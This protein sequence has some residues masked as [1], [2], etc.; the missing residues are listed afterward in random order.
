[1]RFIKCEVCDVK[2]SEKCPFTKYKRVLD[3]EVHYF[4]CKQHADQSERK[5]RE[6]HLENGF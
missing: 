4:C 2:I 1:M 6:K 3:G 5:I